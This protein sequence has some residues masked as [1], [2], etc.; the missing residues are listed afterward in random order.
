MQRAALHFPVHLLVLVI[1]LFGSAV[2]RNST[3][4]F[5]TSGLFLKSLSCFN[6][7]LKEVFTE[8]FFKS[9]L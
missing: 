5:A 6:N 7:S 9:F 8:S 3:S 2:A 1:L 4:K